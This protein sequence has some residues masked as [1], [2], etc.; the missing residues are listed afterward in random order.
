M[1]IL[2]GILLKIFVYL[3][4]RVKFGDGERERKRFWIC[5]FTPQMAA[6]SKAETGWDLSDSPLWFAK[7]QGLGSSSGTFLGSLPESY[8]GNEIGKPSTSSSVFNAGVLTFC[9]TMRGSTNELCIS[10]TYV[11]HSGLLKE[12]T[13]NYFK[14]LVGKN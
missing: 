9:V 4:G 8:M 7:T 14:L 3:K 11:D 1:N 2:K 12:R 6:T 13:L 5:L 10:C